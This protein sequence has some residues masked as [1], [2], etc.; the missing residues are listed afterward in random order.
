[1]LGGIICASCGGAAPRTGPHQKYCAPCSIKA[2]KRRIGVKDAA[3]RARV[4]SLTTSN[5]ERLS[6]ASASGIGDLMRPVTLEWSV[7]IIVPFTY[8]GSKN[9][10]YSLRDSGHLFLRAESKA[11]RDEVTLRLRSAL[12]GRRIVQNRLWLDIFV[13]KSNHKGD[14]VNFVDMI[15]DAVKLAV[16]LD[17]RWYSLRRVDW[18]IA[19]DS[20]QIFVGVGQENVR[21]VQACSSCG[22]LLPFDSFGKK[23][24]NKLGIDRNCR[25]CR[26]ET[27]RA[28]A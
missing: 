7:R 22:R 8:A 1:M 19:K 2:N 11:F 28:V 16:P 27:P 18:E 5:G 17:D 26:A 3:R 9:H 15:C 12:I 25:E 4:K 24:S 23:S 20:P 14:A 10:I 21:D 6:A 13:Q